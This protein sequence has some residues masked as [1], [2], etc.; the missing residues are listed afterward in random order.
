MQLA[1]AGIMNGP[2]PL[3]RGPATVVIASAA[4]LPPCKPRTTVTM[5]NLRVTASDMRIA[6]SFA[7]EPVTAKF[8]TL[9]FPGSVLPMSSANSIDGAFEY[10]DEVWT[11]R[12]ACSQIVSVSSGCECPRL[13]HIIPE[14][15]S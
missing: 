3:R 14:V 8:T 6:I 4:R 10:Q 2:N 9:R 15:A 5:S 11:R 7:S 12:P 1:F 13:M